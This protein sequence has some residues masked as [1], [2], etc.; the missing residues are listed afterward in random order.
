MIGDFHQ[1]L[2]VDIPFINNIVFLLVL[3]YILVAFY[4]NT[5]GRYTLRLQEQQSE[6]SPYLVSDLLGSSN[7]KHRYNIST[8]FLF[9][10]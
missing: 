7:K 10:T 1:T 9:L 8:F 5:L 6:I 4:Y 3:L 2:W